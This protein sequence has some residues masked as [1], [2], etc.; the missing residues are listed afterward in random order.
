VYH[1]K[2]TDRWIGSN[3]TT[4]E[5]KVANGT[6]HVTTCKR[7]EWELSIGE[8]TKLVFTGVGWDA[9]ATLFPKRHCVCFDRY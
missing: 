4:L 1:I 3:N 7:A 6:L 8:F 9:L 5:I 2:F